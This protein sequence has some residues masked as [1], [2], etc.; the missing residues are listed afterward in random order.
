MGIELSITF[1]YHS[2][3][4]MKAIMT[5]LLSFLKCVMSVF[6]IFYLLD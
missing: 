4:S 3:M 6:S 5:A 2:L 1:F